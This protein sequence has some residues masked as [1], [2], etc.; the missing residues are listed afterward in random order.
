[1]GHKSERV[2]SA[3]PYVALVIAIAA[4]LF[5]YL[6]ARTATQKA[7]AARQTLQEQQAIEPL[8]RDARREL[9]RR[10]RANEDDIDAL[11][12]RVNRLSRTVNERHSGGE[13]PDLEAPLRQTKA[14]TPLKSGVYDALAF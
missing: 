12:R 5:S 4:P 10:V 7:S 9:R 3:S 6:E 2:K 1:M 8:E 13:R 11:V 14:K